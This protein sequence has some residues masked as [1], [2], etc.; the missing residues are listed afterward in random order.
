MCAGF[1][2]SNRELYL[3]VMRLISCFEIGYEGELDIDPVSGTAD[4]TK[5]AAQP[6]RFKARFTPWDE[7]QLRKAFVE[8][9]L[10]QPA[11]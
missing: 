11:Q 2:L 8:A 3:I 10:A 9:P 1:L 6:R 4:T 5:L 7:A